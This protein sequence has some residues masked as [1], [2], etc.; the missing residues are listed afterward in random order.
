MIIIPEVEEFVMPPSKYDEEMTKACEKLEA[1]LKKLDD[2]EASRNRKQR[3]MQSQEAN[4]M[5]K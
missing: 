5:E 3:E 2:I 1:N 4:K